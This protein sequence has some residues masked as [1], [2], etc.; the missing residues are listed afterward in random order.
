MISFT[1]LSISGEPLI[2]ETLTI[3][4]IEEGLVYEGS[5]W[6]VESVKTIHGLRFNN[7]ILAYRIK[8]EGKSVVISGDVAA[9]KGEGVENAYST[10]TSLLN[11]ARN[12]DLFIMD[13]DLTHT[14]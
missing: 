13:A 7:L 3:T 2:R 8:A 14:H 12:T 1:L 5:K 10:N 9:P 6:S 11:L 4:D